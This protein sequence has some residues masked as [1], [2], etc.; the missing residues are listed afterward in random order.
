MSASLLSSLLTGQ[1]MVVCL[2]LWSLLVEA[3]TLGKLS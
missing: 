2:F 3:F 1:Q